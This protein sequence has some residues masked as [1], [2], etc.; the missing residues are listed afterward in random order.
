MPS[1]TTIGP[2][3]ILGKLGSGGMGVVYKARDP[4]LNRL[5]ALKLLP[6]GSG[7]AARERFQ[8]EALAIAALNH[9]HICTLYEVGYEPG[10]D[11]REGQPYLVMELLEG[12]TLY[13]RLAAGRVSTTEAITWGAEIADA[14]QAAHARGI[15]HRDLK[16]ANIHITQRG[17]SKVLDFGLAQFAPNPS[18]A[19]AQTLADNP[20][21]PDRAPLTTPGATLGTYAYMSPEQARGEPTDARSDIFSLGV[22]L[23]EMAAGQAPF[24]GRTSA[25]ISAAILMRTPPPPSSVREGLPTRLDDIIAQCLEKNPELRFQSAADLRVGLRRQ[26][27]SVPPASGVGSQASGLRGEFERPQRD[28]GSTSVATV[29]ATRPR[30]RWALAAAAACATVVVASIAWFALRPR[31]LPP[32]QLAFRQLTFTGQVQDAAVSPDGKF[33][34]H[35]DTDTQGTSLHLMSV[36]NASDTQIVPPGAGCCQSPTFS[37][38]GNTIYFAA[39]NLL[40]A[41]PVLG[42]EVRTV[43][44]DVCS[45]AAFSPDGQTIAVVGPTS[46]GSALYTARADGSQLRLLRDPS[47]AG[48]NSRCWIG[49][50]LFP[51]APAWSPDGRWIAVDR[52]GNGADV[53]DHI[54]LIAPDTG[55]F[56][57]FGPDLGLS[58]S[59]LSWLPDGSGLILAL[60]KPPTAPSQVWEL[61]YPDG[62]LTQLTHDLQGYDR[63]TV[64]PQTAGG[65]ALALVHSAPESSVWLQ[66]TRG[67]AFAQL[68]GGGANQDGASGLAWSPSGEVVSFRLLGSEPQIWIEGGAAPARR[69][70]LPAMPAVI[71]HPTIAPDG[72]IFF[73]GIQPGGSWQ[74]YR[75]AATGGEITSVAPNSFYGV[76]PALLD[77][78]R[79]VAFLHIAKNALDQNAWVDSTTGG[80]GH[81]LWSGRIF[82]NFLLAM[83]DQTAILVLAQ[84][85]GRDGVFTVVAR[86]GVATPTKLSWFRTWRGDP[87]GPP[88]GITPDGKSFIATVSHGSV[89]NLWAFPLDASAPYALTHFN[90]LSIS[91]FAYSHD[92]RLALSRGK[93]NRDAVLATGLGGSR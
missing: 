85:N 25:D 48:Y 79:S 63:V 75:A 23:Y 56:K 31:A 51:D 5:V 14:L 29:S 80:P 50:P 18:D 15:L 52:S 28:S 32:A 67:G 40:Q 72:T 91:A 11:G 86:D 22:V 87:T 6:E 46:G 54:E 90:D 19:D 24:Q 49:G 62:K 64:A 37:P 53:S 38:D 88:Y 9:P 42:G 66:A 83:P 89:D 34:V 61:T 17:T 3:E 35:V 33:L 20:V 58:V 13:A 73:E 16:P 74:I 12:E 78:G 44:P 65:V 60:R 10:T 47:P 2:F 68:P 8:R 76:L 39:T 26:L 70:P 27:G 36:A 81:Q 1:P 59:D 71:G 21:G 30:R 82:T 77:T 55:R 84:G 92:G 57:T 69:L 45:S 43:A 41:V 4:R 93:P 7:A